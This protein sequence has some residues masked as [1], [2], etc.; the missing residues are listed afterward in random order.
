MND[1]QCTL[2][3]LEAGFG[4]AF[5]GACLGDGVSIKQSAVMALYGEGCTD[6]EFAALP[7]SENT[8]DW[9]R[10][11]V[12]ELGQA[13]VAFF[14]AAALRYYLPQLLLSVAKNYDRSSMRVVGALSAVCPEPHRSYSNAE[15]IDW[16][17]LNLVQ[18]DAV[19]KFMA[20]LPHLVALDETDRERVS[21]AFEEYW[22]K[23]LVEPPR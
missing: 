12:E 8:N 20:C 17:L 15:A 23:F 18:R 13:S 19:A 6:E 16:A 10:L 14:D 5:A 1:L 21:Q 11:S 4:S 9:Q 7:T 22:C 3:A 2:Q